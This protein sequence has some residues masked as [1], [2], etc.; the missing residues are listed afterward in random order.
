[1]R[2]H[3]PSVRSSTLLVTPLAMATVALL[4]AGAL[5]LDGSANRPTARPVP[6]WQEPG[7][8]VV[9]PEGTPITVELATPL[10]ATVSRAGDRFAATVVSP[11][12]VQ[13]LVA[14]PTGARVLGH[15]AKVS[16]TS[17][18]GSAGLELVYDQLELEGRSYGIGNHRPT[19]KDAEPGAPGWIA[20]SIVGGV[21]RAS[22]GSLASSL[23]APSPSTGAWFEAPHRVLGQGTRLVFRLD[24][25]VRVIRAS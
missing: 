13:E 3:V 12:M 16:E 17:T 9:M 4:A 25:P 5:T 22:R 24:R 23:G 18:R 20:A 10:S 14:V 7:S 19:P 15:V 2:M 6:A 11:V 8:M 21:L 1:M